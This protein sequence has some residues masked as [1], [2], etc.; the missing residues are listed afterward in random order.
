VSRIAIAVA[1]ASCSGKTTL[2]QRLSERLDATLVRIDDYY[3]PF[4]HMTYEE[5]CEV[6]FD[7]PDSIDSP[8]LIEHVRA[9]LAGQPVDAPRYDFTRHARFPTSERV[10]PRSVVIVEGLFALCYPELTDV[11]DVRAF[12]DAPEQVCLDRRVYR[13]VHERG[14]T[15]GEVIGRFHGH[16]APMYRQHVLPRRAQATVV[17]S[18]VE[19]IDLG[20]RAL[21]ETLPVAVP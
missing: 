21:L 14:R 9:L 3:R 12:V 15:P 1:G 10:E 7:H 8:L 16:V 13:D 2:A 18:G 4:D 17:V 6:N 11:C 5:R 19:P 20:A